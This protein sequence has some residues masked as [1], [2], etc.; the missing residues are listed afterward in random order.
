MTFCKTILLFVLLI[1]ITIFASIE[2]VGQEGLGNE[3]TPAW[4]T[5]SRVKFLEDEFNKPDYK[6]VR[7][8]SVKKIVRVTGTAPRANDNEFI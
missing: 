3:E 8:P 2:N 7:G 5:A 6:G 4:A 1:L